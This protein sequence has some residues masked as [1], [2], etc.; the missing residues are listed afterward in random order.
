MINDKDY[1]KISA[2]PSVTIDGFGEEEISKVAPLIGKF[3][4][5]Y[6]SKD[7]TDEVW[8]TKILTEHLPDKSSDEIFSI[9]QEILS[10]VDKFEETFLASQQ[11]KLRGLNP[12]E[13]IA[14]NIQAASIGMS[15]KDL[16]DK[17]AKLDDAIH[18]SNEA[19]AKTLKTKSGEINMNPNL[20]GLLAETEHANSFN[21]AAALSDSPFEARV[22]QSNA[23]N[24][25]DV[26]IY[27]KTTN[28][29]AGRYQLKF[30][31]DADKTI[32]AIKVGDYRGQQ[33]IVPSE[34]L[35]EVQKA[36]PN[37]KIS[38]RIEIDGVKSEPLTK[39][40][41]KSLQTKVQGDKEFSEVNWTA[42]DG[43][44]LA[45]QLGKEVIFS[46][47]AGAATGA[48]FYVAKKFLSGEEIKGDEVIV[49]ALKS[50]ADRGI[51]TAVSAA[52]T[53]A[54]KSGAIPTLAK[55]SA[56]TISNIACKAVE[57]IKIIG[58]FLSGEISGKEAVARL[59]WL[60]ASSYV[61]ELAISGL[62]ASLLAAVPVICSP[63]GVA[64]GLAAAAVV[65]VMAFDETILDVA[66]TFFEATSEIVSDI[67][68][69]MTTVA[70]GI[71]NAI[72]GFI[73]WLFG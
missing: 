37:R 71:G 24:S 15:E 59:L 17:L 5:S 26:G 64:V 20:D 7:T 39:E 40:K 32:A 10:G 31:A 2:A 9:S 16:V 41:I 57:T 61:C 56:R 30:C 8:L 29:L 45:I 19:L 54:A 38:D 1:K 73:D 23:K 69:C 36:F 52:L 49:E 72:G 50:G 34:Q 22:L 62:S 70:E 14:D 3:I 51:K 63:I 12:Q 58:D 66:E 27:D 21:R 28:H 18:Q 4:R 65:G 67:W 11:A 6:M 46:S 35:A 68:D 33:I 44:D 53:V 43:R 25:V 13:W 48:G 60:A 47:A 55:V 42:Y